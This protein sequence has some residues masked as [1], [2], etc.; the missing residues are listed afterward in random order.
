MEQYGIVTESFSH[1]DYPTL[2]D[3]WAHVACYNNFT[4][5]EDPNIRDFWGISLDSMWHYVYDADAALGGAIWGMIDETFMLPDTLPGF[6]DWWGIVDA[7]V[8]PATYAGHTVGYGEW[9]IIDTWRRRKPEF[10]NTRKAYS[11]F[12]LLQ[13]RFSA[14]PE[15]GILQVPV[16][17]RYDHTNFKELRIRYQVEG[18]NRQAGTIDLPPHRKGILPL[19]LGA[20]DPADTIYL[21]AR[22]RRGQLIDQYMLSLIPEDP[23]REHQATGPVGIR[24]GDS[25]LTLACAEGRLLHFSLAS[26]LLCA[27]QDDRDSIPLSGPYPNIRT[28]GDP[29]I[30][31]YHHI[32]SHEGWTLKEFTWEETAEGAVLRSRGTLADSIA[33]QFTILVT[34]GGGMTVEHA[35]DPMPGQYI[36]ELGVKFI[37][38]DDLDA[39]SWKRNGY[40]S[41]Y[42]E[43]HLS[44]IEG[45][46]PLYPENLKKY[47]TIPP[48][49]W[50]SDTKS[51][52]YDGTA[53]EKPNDRLSHRARATKENIREYSLIRAAH[54]VLTVRGNGEVHC[55]LA[56]ENGMLSLYVSN[57]MD[58]VDLSWGNYQHNTRIPVKWSGSARIELF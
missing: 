16:Y 11:P 22:D 36:R 21:E 35:I 44:S 20:W 29:V 38:P 48:R 49:D 45:T 9:G 17:N 41:H 24:Q 54:P 43:S 31:S 14:L 57:E 37:L 47:R 6:N 4:V 58:Y 15:D 13:T 53:D 34:Y 8:I 42:P 40:W 10:W 51:F 50:S 3:E 25:I 18:S 28:K 52:Y 12:K 1:A 55:R 46:E 33:V 23:E 39:V 56:K 27:I 7:H 32:I 30:Y 5:I 2:F 26:G 19:D